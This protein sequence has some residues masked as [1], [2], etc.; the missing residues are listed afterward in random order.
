VTAGIV[1]GRRAVVEEPGGAPIPGQQAAAPG[2]LI[3][4]IQTDASINPG[5][6]GGP[7]FN[8]R[9]EVIGI[10]TLIL[11]PGAQGGMGGNIG[12]GFAIPID[13]A[14]RIVPEL[15]AKGR[16]AHPFLGVSTQEITETIAREANLPVREGLLVA[17]ADPGT[18]AARAGLRGGTRGQDARSRRVS[19]G[20]DIIT[21]IDG[22]PLRRPEQLLVYLETQ[23]SVGDT[24]TL[25]VVRD[26]QTLQVQVQLAE[27]PAR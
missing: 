23:K 14:K 3:N 27:R 24:V 10:N 9:G 16:Y 11:S 22:Q 4:A 6:S 12:I 8:A 19:L 18:P 21:A 25:S 17:Q 1:S 13:Y 20:G 7:L 26:G 5:N 15:I 2:L